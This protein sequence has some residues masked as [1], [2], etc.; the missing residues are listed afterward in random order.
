LGG[1]RSGR[2]SSRWDVIAV[3]EAAYQLDVSEE[4]WL[5]D[6]C[7]RL[8]D[9]F[10][11]RQGLAGYHIDFEP[12]GLAIGTVVESANASG[13]ARALEEQLASLLRRARRA[14]AGPLVRARA[15]LFEK[16]LWQGIREP[17]TLLFA[18]ER[19]TIG[20]RWMHYLGRKAVDQLTL[21]STHVDG[22]GATAFLGVIE[23]P[24][25]LRPAERTMYQQ[26]HA[27][28]Q[29]GLRL[30]R[31]LGPRTA[32]EAPAGGAVLDS[33]GAVVHAEGNAKQR[34]DSLREGAARMGSARSQQMGRGPEALA[35]WQGLVDGTW[36][37]VERFDTDGRRFV[38][39][40]A[41][42]HRVRDPRGLTNMETRVAALAIRGYADKL[43]AYHLGIASGTVSGHLASAMRKLGVQRRT[44]L[45]R[46]LGPLFPGPPD[47][48]TRAE[49]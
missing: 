46:L 34:V 15:A 49:R 14:S 18:S 4:Q 21:V 30:R 40:H 38:L 1:S 22:L 11:N 33:R 6:C 29:A 31:T 3:V 24:R 13:V 17:S 32:V 27:H 43:I 25:R 8:H 26:V 10:G 19:K 16:I 20:P 42:P 7:D 39:A 28:I 9:L 41:N 12:S 45:V 48:P 5:Q 36:S 47:D 44:D 35:A 37:L 2:R 23:E